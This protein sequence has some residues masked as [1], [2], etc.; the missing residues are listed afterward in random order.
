MN[1]S[2]SSRTI[3]GIDTT[4]LLCDGRPRDNDFDVIPHSDKEK[5]EL[6]ERVYSLLPEIRYLDQISTTSE[7]RARGTI[8]TVTICLETA[9]DARKVANYLK[10]FPGLKNA[11]VRMDRLDS[12]TYHSDSLLSEEIECRFRVYVHRNDHHTDQIQP[13]MRDNYQP[14]L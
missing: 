13:T 1:S 2:E 9:V 8:S 3:E 5:K 6:N 7:L 10:S 12:P 4:P 11:L 14:P